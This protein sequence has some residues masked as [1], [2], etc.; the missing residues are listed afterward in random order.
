MTTD[1][2]ISGLM[3][4]APKYSEGVRK[5]VTQVIKDLRPWTYLPDDAERGVRFYD[6]GHILWLLE[7]NI[8]EA[9]INAEVN[10]WVLA[11]LIEA[12]RSDYWYAH[13]KNWD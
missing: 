10:M 1:L 7:S 9:A 8:P 2:K 4:D 6:N 13:E 5:S 11:A 12:G 3:V